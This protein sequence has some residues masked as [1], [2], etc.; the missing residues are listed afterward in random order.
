MKSNLKLRVKNKN[1]EFCELLF[2]DN[3]IELIESHKKE[4]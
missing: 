4:G 1:E 2:K 3:I